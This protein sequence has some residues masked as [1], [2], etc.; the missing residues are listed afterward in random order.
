MLKLQHR[1]MCGRALASR[2]LPLHAAHHA[3]ALAL[4]TGRAQYRPRM[5]RIW[6]MSISITDT[7]R[8]GEAGH[9]QVNGL[10]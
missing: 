6:E 3:P 4:R 7:K 5:R 8:L 2:D 1:I 9:V 10:A